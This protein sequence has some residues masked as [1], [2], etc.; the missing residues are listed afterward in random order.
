MNDWLDYKGSG[1]ARAYTANG[2]MSDAN[3]SHALRVDKSS[4]YEGGKEANRTLK[5]IQSTVNK[6]KTLDDRFKKVDGT[7]TPVGNSRGN[8]ATQID[9]KN[10]AID[11]ELTK[12][13]VEYMDLLKSLRSLIAKYEGLSKYFGFTAPY[14]DLNEAKNI[15]NRGVPTSVFEMNI[16]AKRR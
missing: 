1:S 2:L 6:I 13:Q 3:I 4:P 16:R 10:K 5:E 11:S 8:K 15:L 9:S 14:V 7:K 12:I